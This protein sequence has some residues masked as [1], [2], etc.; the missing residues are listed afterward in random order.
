MY[1]RQAYFELAAAVILIPLPTAFAT[2]SGVYLDFSQPPTM[3]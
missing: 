2:W 3:S 1:R